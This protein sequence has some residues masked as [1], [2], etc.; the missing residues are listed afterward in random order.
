MKNNKFA[1]HKRYIRLENCV[2]ASN[3]NK[4]ESGVWG[5][6]K[7][8]ELRELQGNTISWSKKYFNIAMHVH[9]STFSWIFQGNID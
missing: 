3:D 6:G 1:N 2:N 5:G 4:G 8:R 7:G 9:T